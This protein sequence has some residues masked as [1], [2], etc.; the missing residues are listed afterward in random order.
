MSPD[1][2]K[3]L[4]AKTTPELVHRAALLLDE[5]VICIEVGNK[6]S[7]YGPGP[8]DIVKQATVA[9]PERLDDDGDGDNPPVILQEK[10]WFRDH[11]ALAIIREYAPGAN[12]VCYNSCFQYIL[13]SPIAPNVVVE[14]AGLSIRNPHEGTILKISEISKQRTIRN[15]AIVTGAVG[16]MLLFRKLL[17]FVA[18][19]SATHF[20]VS[21]KDKVANFLEQLFSS[22]I[23]VAPDAENPAGDN[24]LPIP[25][26]AGV[27]DG[28]DPGSGGTSAPIAENPAGDSAPSIPPV[29]GVL[30]GEGPGSGGTSAPDA[31]NPPPEITPPNPSPSPSPSASVPDQLDI[32]KGE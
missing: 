10:T 31:E 20:L 23:P 17:T 27:L 30:D 21:V 28:E 26:V 4:R 25:P 1:V 18:A 16:S 19:G 5:T 7:A 24:T 15:V 32:Y 8:I 6:F 2:S 29:A 13:I 14:N 3:P 11:K 9:R 12:V 22:P